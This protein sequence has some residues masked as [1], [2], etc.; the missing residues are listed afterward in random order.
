MSYLRTLSIVFSLLLAGSLTTNLK[1]QE[2]LTTNQFL[3]VNG[4]EFDQEDG[5]EGTLGSYDPD[6]EAYTHIDSFPAASATDMVIEDDEAFV[7]ADSLL[8]K[9][10]LNTY[11]RTEESFDFQDVVGLETYKDYLIVTKREEENQDEW[12]GIYDRE[13]F[14][15][16][17]YFPSIPAAASQIEIRNDHAYVTLPGSFFSDDGAMARIDLDAQEVDQVFDFEE[18]GDGIGP[19]F[20][21]DDYVYMTTSAGNIIEFNTNDD[22]WEVID[23]PDIEGIS[24]ALGVENG[25]LYAN[26]GGMTF[27]TFDLEE[28]EP[29]NFELI[30]GMFAGGAFD[31]LNYNFLFGS[32]DFQAGDNEISHYDGEGELL[33][34][35]DDLDI[36]PEVF[37]VHYENVQ[38]EPAIS[39]PENVEPGQTA[40]YETALNE[41]NEYNWTV[42]YGEIESEEEN[43]VQVTWSEEADSGYVSVEEVVE[44]TDCSSEHEFAVNIDEGTSIA[45]NDQI[46]TL[47]LYPNPAADQVTISG[48]ENLDEFT[49]MVTSLHGQQ[50]AQHSFEAADDVQ[51]DVSGLD[52]GTYLLSI[53]TSEATHQ[54][55]LIVK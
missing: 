48:Q 34:N 30:E 38:P 42:E 32:T 5:N 19:I 2:C 55:K 43:E 29:E 10:N 40:T 31:T 36:I 37:A 41:G 16:V 51:V 25:L 1:G 47:S 44:G 33:N 18:Q 49:V 45:D 46:Q 4:G 26:F 50:V 6:E 11:E 12:V 14:S 28:R 9:Y 52:Q 39:G 24:T 53:Q 7:L 22:S 54:E 23:H 8:L 13:D 15:N 20:S 17:T 27:G 3:I 21:K 35:V